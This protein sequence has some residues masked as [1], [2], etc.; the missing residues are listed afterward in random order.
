[1]ENCIRVMMMTLLV[2]P[3]SRQLGQLYTEGTG[4]PNLTL[5]PDPKVIMAPVLE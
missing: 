5:I 4:K 2:L 1:M 3:Q